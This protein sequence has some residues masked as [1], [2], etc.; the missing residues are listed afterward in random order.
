MHV[1][2]CDKALMGRHVLPMQA[3]TCSQAGSPTVN[4]I[5][6]VMLKILIKTC[7]CKDSCESKT[8]DNPILVETSVRGAWQSALVEVVNHS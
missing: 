1:G 6:L 8:M 4:S 3:Y 5:P 7:I 2:M